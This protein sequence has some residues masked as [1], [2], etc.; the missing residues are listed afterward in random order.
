[1]VSTLKDLGI[2]DATIIK[3]S[4]EKLSLTN[5]EALAYWSNSKGN[6]QKIGGSVCHL[7]R[8]EK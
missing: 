1:M 4:Q 3:K 6:R 2:Q 8:W 5:K 7:N